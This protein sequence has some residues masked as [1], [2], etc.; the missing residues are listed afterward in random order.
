MATLGQIFLES[1]VVFLVGIH[2]GGDRSEPKGHD[3]ATS[4]DCLGNAIG[5]AVNISI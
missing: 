4:D 2:V 5:P 1:S 3:T